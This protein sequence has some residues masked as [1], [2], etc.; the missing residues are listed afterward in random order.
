MQTR[1]AS[2]IIVDDSPEDR[3]LYRRLLLKDRDCGY[4]IQEAESGE[5]ALKLLQSEPFHCI[6]LDYRLPDMDGIELLSAMSEHNR[7][8][9]IPKI[10][11]TGQGSEAVAVEAMKNGA[12]DYLVKGELTGHHFLRTIHH[13]IDFKNTENALLEHF[14]FLETLIDT[15]PNPIFYKNAKGEYT[16]C[17]KA[18]EA[19]IGLSKEA[20]VGKTVYDM[21]PG[22]LA[23]Q[24]H[25]M[26]QKLFRNPGVQI[27]ETQARYADGTLRDVIFYKAT[28]TDSYG[29]VGGLV[30][31]MLDITERKGMEARLTKAKEELESSVAELRQA[32]QLIRDQQKSVIEEERLKLLLQLSGATAH[33]LNQPLT[34]ILGSIELLK[35]KNDYPKELDDR[36]NSIEEAG[37]EMAKIIERIQ[38]IR[39]DE[40]V[41]YLQDAIINLGQKLNI[42]SIEDSDGDFEKIHSSV[43]NWTDIALS[44]TKG[45]REAVRELKEGRFDI[46][47]L[48]YMLG[49]GTGFDFLKMGRQEGIDIPVIVVTGQGNEIVAS[50]LIQEGA[51]DYIPKQMLNEKSL[52]RSITNVMERHRLKKELRRATEKMAEMS[53][54]DELTGLYNRRHFGEALERERARSKRYGGNLSLCMVDLDLFKNINDTYGHSAGDKVLS[55]IGLLLRESIR[56]SDLACR[57][58]GEEFAVVLPNTGLN[59][60]R[61]LAARFMEKLSVHEFEHDSSKFKVTV[62]I[63]I[64]VLD[65]A[66]DIAEAELVKM[67]DTALFRAKEEGRNRIVELEKATLADRR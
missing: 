49:D 18:Y 33:E 37:R 24:Y 64:A 48:D 13:V 44:R 2:I 15:I 4:L 55:E 53:T 10:F 66:S 43:R 31:V 5:E 34:V 20:I 63:G 28:F 3:E 32:N 23:E 19:Y 56:E 7:L 62:S 38:S 29:N 57:Y 36:L 8:Q 52:S 41:P 47:L 35:L 9:R 42:L 30:G 6:L 50:K 27:F 60:A 58:G 46:V 54:R 16:G 39:R 45:V 40:T 1:T 61:Q 25:E 26:D 22:G 65:G 67:A 12:S 59:D 21:E 14:T 17:N 51:Y 11:L